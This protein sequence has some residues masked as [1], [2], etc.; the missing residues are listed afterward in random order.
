MKGFVA[1]REYLHKMAANARKYR[2]MKVRLCGLVL[3]VSSLS[4]R[5][6]QAAEGV[7]LNTYAALFSASAVAR[8]CWSGPSSGAWCPYATVGAGAI[9]AWFDGVAKQIGSASVAKAQTDPALTAG[10]GI[11]HLFTRH[12][13]LR[14][15]ARHF[16][17][18]VDE[19]AS[20]GG[21]VQDYG[22]LRLSAGVSVGF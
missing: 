8:Y 15:D 9:H 19:N 22:F 13:G 21:Y 7:D 16:R 20:D 1:A 5:A 6:A 17:A 14:F 11:T 3:L 18:L 10:V 12:V 2:P 4:S